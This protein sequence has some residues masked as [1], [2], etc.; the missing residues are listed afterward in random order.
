MRNHQYCYPQDTCLESGGRPQSSLL[1]I[2]T[3]AVPALRQ[4]NDLERIDFSI[5]FFVVLDL[6][7]EISPSFRACVSQERTLTS[8]P[9]LNIY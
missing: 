5:R 4:E 6:V 7:R 3:S 1:R 8:Q 9:F 2:L